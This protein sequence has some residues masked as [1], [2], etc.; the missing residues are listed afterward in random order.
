MLAGSQTYSQ[1]DSVAVYTIDSA[2]VKTIDGIIKAMYD[3]ISGPAGPRN[4]NR[5]HA[6]CLPTAQFNAVVPG[7]D[8][9]MVL[10]AGTKDQYV[11]NAGGYFEKNAFYETE[12]NRVTDQ[13]MNIAQVFSTYQSRDVK[14]GEVVAQGINSIQLVYNKN[15]WWVVNVIW[16]EATEKYPLPEKYQGQKKK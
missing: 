16:N 6:L 15:R 1:K 13:F 14:D 5:F 9:K 7:K 4:C 8:G 2:D 3:V 12:V 10:I 11:K